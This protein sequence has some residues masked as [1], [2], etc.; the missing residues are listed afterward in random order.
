MSAPIG[1]LLAAGSSSRLGGDKLPLPLP[2]GCPVGV[3]AAQHLVAVLCD[4]VAV[5]RSLETPLAA[6][7]ERV[8]CRVIVNRQAQLGLSSSLASAIRDASATSVGWVV[9]LADMPWIRPDTIAA[10]ARHLQAGASI[11]APCYAGQR[12]HPVALAAHW[13]D[14]LLRLRGDQG[15]RAL[16][17]DHAGALSTVRVSDPGVVRDIDVPADLAPRVN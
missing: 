13:R 9:A 3:R 7:L 6:Q 2:V 5:V 4:T 1:I 15:A 10:I 8:G 16:L 14:E 11:A 17:R 12:G